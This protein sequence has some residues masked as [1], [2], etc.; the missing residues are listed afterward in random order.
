MPDRIQSTRASRDGRAGRAIVSGGAGFIGSHLC[1]ALVAAGWTVVALDDLFR[2][3]E[4]HL[5]ALSGSARFDAVLADASDAE[6]WDAA[7]GVLGGLREGRSGPL[8]VWHL[9]AVNGT[10]WFH[11]APELVVEVNLGSLLACL[12]FCQSEDARLVFTSSPEAFGVPT[13]QPMPDE[14]GS[15]F[16]AAS[17]HVRHSYGAS[18]YLGEVLVQHAVRGGLDARVVRP[19]NVY[20]PRGVS[21]EYGQVVPIFLAQARGGGPLTLHGDGSQTRSFCHVSDCVAALVLAGALEAAVGFEDGTG[22]GEP[23]AGRS[24]NVGL[25]QETSM[26]ELAAMVAGMVDGEVAVETAEDHPGD[27]DR[28]CPSIEGAQRD[29]GWV[30]TIPLEQGLRMT[31]EAMWGG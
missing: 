29:L 9:A 20:G 26:A 14:G 21:D 4:H 12:E 27:S 7:L 19:F 2:G 28:R 23:L 11:E 5:Q 24:W 22:A 25:P 1:E 3:D 30:P 6:A 15:A 13:T 16:D 8:V 10:R 31:L 17:E 18:K